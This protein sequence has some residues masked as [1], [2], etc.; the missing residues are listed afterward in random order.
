MI[1]KTVAD[2]EIDF[3]EFYSILDCRNNA[4]ASCETSS[5]IACTAM[6]I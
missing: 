1:R 4:P 6:K 3:Y 5:L 2:E